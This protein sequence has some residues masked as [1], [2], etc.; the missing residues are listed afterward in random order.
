MYE[1]AIQPRPLMGSV[2]QSPPRKR[3]AAYPGFV[4]LAVSSLFPEMSETIYCYGE[5]YS[6]IRRST[7]RA[8][9]CPPHRF[10]SL[11]R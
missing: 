2:Y 5:D 11:A 3:A 10:H 6:A 4:S 8:T 9:W 7:F 1:Q